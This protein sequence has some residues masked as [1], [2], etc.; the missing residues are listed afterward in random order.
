MTALTK[1]VNTGS[2]EVS[3]RL[4]LMRKI[5]VVEASCDAVEL[6]EGLQLNLSF[7]IRSELIIHSAEILN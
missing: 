3:V 4:C 7:G 1:F 2:K 5:F 6:F